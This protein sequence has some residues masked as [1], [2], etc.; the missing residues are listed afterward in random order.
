VKKEFAL[1]N[2]NDDMGGKHTITFSMAGPVLIG[3]EDMT[4]HF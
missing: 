3:L 2:Y 4:K 1:R